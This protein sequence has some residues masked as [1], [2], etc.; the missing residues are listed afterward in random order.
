MR[1]IGGACACRGL[2]TALV[3]QADFGAGSSS[4]STKLVHGG[5]RYLEKAVFNLDYSQLR[6]V[7]DALHER[8]RM[9]DNA[10]HLSRPLPIMTV[11][12]C[13]CCTACLSLSRPVSA[14]PAASSLH[15][16][17]G[18]VLLA[19]SE[20]VPERCWWASAPQTAGERAHQTQQP[21]PHAQPCYAWWEVPYY[22]A[23]LK[24]YDLVANVSNLAWSRFLSAAESMRRFP[25][26]APARADGLTLKGTVRSVLCA[27]RLSLDAAE[28]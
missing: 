7:F 26:L 27:K 6:L 17:A 12:D 18:H 19:R 2:R 4:R 25:T 28:T 1:Y 20:G 15:A 9:L 11:R 22:W 5:V 23:G 14:Q 13:L 21:H 16:D 3:E 10:P 8:R 24:A